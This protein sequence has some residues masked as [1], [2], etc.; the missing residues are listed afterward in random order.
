PVKTVPISMARANMKRMLR[1]VTY[2]GNHVLL[3]Q[4]AKPKAGV[5]SM[6]DIR[7]LWQLQDRTVHEMER[8]LKEAYPRW[9]KA[10]QRHE[11]NWD[12]MDLGDHA[13][14]PFWNFENM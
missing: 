11:Q 8:R 4:H 1:E 7:V 12:P 9:L 3:T 14:V 2:E 13:W 10:R 5:I 6:Q